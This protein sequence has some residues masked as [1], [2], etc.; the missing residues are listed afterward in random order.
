E[1]TLNKNVPSD[2]SLMASSRYAKL[3]GNFE[4]FYR[5]DN[6]QSDPAIS[7]LFDFPTNDPS[8]AAIG[9]PA[10]GFGGAI[11]F[12]GTTLGE[13]VLPNDRPHQVKIYGTYAFSALNMGV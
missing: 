11:R 8:Y 7:S 13:G 2:V 4:G 9:V 12:Q 5:S 1:H 3:K 6:G 10:Y